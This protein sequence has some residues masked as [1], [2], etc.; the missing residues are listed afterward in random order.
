MLITAA[1]Y[2][3]FM[4][5]H[6]TGVCIA[7]T[8]DPSGAP[9]GL[10]CSSLVSVAVEPPILSVSLQRDS[11][12]LDA[13]LQ[14]RRFAVH[15]LHEDGAEAARRFSQPHAVRFIE[16]TWSWG[17]G[18][19]PLLLD[20][21]NAI[22]ECSLHTTV[23]VADHVV[24]FGTVHDLRIVAARPPLV[25]ARRNFMSV[26]PHLTRQGASRPADTPSVEMTD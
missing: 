9:V 20:D 10:T 14:R 2:R 22:A 11:K 19:L 17:P 18:G 1:A 16:G 13:V 7:T 8:T 4:A 24:V 26:P 3:D 12:T 21:A 6:A 23:A 5:E 15:L 25:Y